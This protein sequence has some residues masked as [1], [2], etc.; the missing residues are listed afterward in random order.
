[1][2]ILGD[3]S[4][5][6][7]LLAGTVAAYSSTALIWTWVVIR[8]LS[9][10]VSLFS[11]NKTKKKENCSNFI[12]CDYNSYFGQGG[13]F[14][15]GSL[16]VSNVLARS[17]WVLVRFSP[18]SVTHLSSVSFYFP[19]TKQRR[20]NTALTS[21]WYLH[22]YLFILGAGGWWNKYMKLFFP[23]IQF[24]CKLSLIV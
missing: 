18:I 11:I 6:L 1:M 19:S 3:Y 10:S 2:S 4:I 17:R 22:I 12:L 8:L 13:L 7:V 9:F 15:A 20:K 16:P 5:I 21:N 23:K 14:K 24:Q